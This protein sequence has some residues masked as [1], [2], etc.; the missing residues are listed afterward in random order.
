MHHRK[1]RKTLLPAASPAGR[2]QE[3]RE[4]EEATEVKPEALDFDAASAP[5]SP[6][7]AQPPAAKRVRIASGPE[8]PGGATPRLPAAPAAAFRYPLDHQWAWTGTVAVL[9]PPKGAVPPTSLAA[10]QA[11][12]V[13]A[14]EL[15]GTLINRRLGSH[16]SPSHDWDT[17]YES[18]T[19]KLKSLVYFDSKRVAVFTSCGVAGLD[20]LRKRCIAFVNVVGVPVE[21]Y[22]SVMDDHYRLPHKGMWDVL[23][24]RS[25]GGAKLDG[26]F[27]CGAQAGRAGDA[28]AKDRRFA[29]NVGIA[30]VTPDE[31]FKGNAPEPYRLNMTQDTKSD[32]SAQAQPEELAVDYTNCG[33]KAATPEIVLLVGP[34][35]AGKTTFAKRALIPFGYSHVNQDRLGSRDK[36]V[37]FCD[38]A[39]RDGQRVV[40]DN[41]NPDRNSRRRYTEVAAYHNCPVRCFWFDTD[42]TVARRL[43]RMRSLASEGQIPVVPEDAY[44]RYAAHLESPSLAEDFTEIRAL[45]FRFNFETPKHHQ[46]YDGT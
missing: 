4:E 45:R 32:P 12:A 44:Q 38:A 25:A 18:V 3:G 14:F 26:S 33:G 7:L 8:R 30:F 29:R 36:C 24:G 2:G 39:L 15:E 19:Q 37:S 13:A 1:A 10:P 20:D 28:S 9:C 31:L 6:P 34:P 11:H 40:V 41:T 17:A 42:L 5:L 16:L 23:V 46:L 27:F 35:G 22:V 43:N 21:V